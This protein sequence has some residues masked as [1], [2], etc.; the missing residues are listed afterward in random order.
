MPV[1]V[2]AVVLF[3]SGW[4]VRSHA[5]S[6]V[7]SNMG[8]APQS[9]AKVVDMGD[10][11]RDSVA[12]RA[13]VP[14]GAVLI[15][16]GKFLMGDPFGSDGCENEVPQ[17]SVF[18]S[19]FYMDRT[20][21]TKALWD[22]VRA[23]GLEHGYDL[24]EGKG[25][26]GNH[27][28]HSIRW[29]DAVNW[30]NARSE[31]EGLKP[32]YY[33]S[34]T[35]D[36]VHRVGPIGDLPNEYVRWDAN[37]YRLPTEAE[38]EKAARGGLVGQRFPWGDTISHSHA[39]YFS[40]NDVPYDINPTQG[41]Y[42]DFVDGG[43]FDVPWTSPVGSFPPNGYGLYDMIGNVSEWCWDRYDPGWYKESGATEPD[44]VGPNRG[45]F[46]MLRGGGWATYPSLVR[47]A[48]R[49]Y[50]PPGSASYDDHGFRCVR[51]RR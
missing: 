6:P 44:P 23:W 19:A 51:S 13:R 27:P 16:A 20:E 33:N 49:G 48:Y 18:V 14:D 26:G 39:N 21:V 3:L 47:S 41:F 5:V 25:K 4:E 7:V 10:A 50:Y 12:E 31:M 43:Q 17:H 40:M 1:S 42:P 37:G 29:S 2:V 36:V 9:G 45:N 11:D 46:R 24:D 15:E 28:V 22:K 30:C 32:C 34:E 8:A 38:W 35:E